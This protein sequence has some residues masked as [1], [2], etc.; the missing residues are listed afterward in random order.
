[1]C[2]Q[3]PAGLQLRNL[4]V[5]GLTAVAA[6]LQLPPELQLCNLYVVGLT[7][8]AAVLQLPTDQQRTMYIVGLIV[9]SSCHPA[10]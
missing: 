7:A 2:L 9:R 8:V 6:V 3:L 5:V 10:T 4:Y 1:M